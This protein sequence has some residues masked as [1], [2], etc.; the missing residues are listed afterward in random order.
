MILLKELYLGNC[1]FKS[2]WSKSEGCV[3]TSETNNVIIEVI[4]Q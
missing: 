3:L 2:T 4:R 1:I